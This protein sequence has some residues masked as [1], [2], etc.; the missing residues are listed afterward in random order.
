MNIHEID[1]LGKQALKIAR[2]TILSY[3]GSE[4][5]VQYKA[6]AT[7]VTIADQ[8]AEEHMREFFSK[9]MDC[10][11]VGEEHG[12]KDLKK[13][14]VWVM[15]PIDGTKSFVREVPLFGS[16]VAC[17]KN[18]EPIW[19]SIDIHAQNKQVIAGKG[20]GCKMNGAPVKVSQ[21]SSKS[22]S[23]LLTGTVNTFSSFGM[24]FQLDRLRKDFGLYRGWGDCFGYFQVL[25]GKAEAMVDPVVSLWDI[26][27][28][29]I[30]FE[31]AGGKFSN[32]KGQNFEE[33]LGDITEWNFASDEFTGVGSNGHWHNKVLARF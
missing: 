16:M 32:L 22:Q 23:C 2:K 14:Y 11:F 9:E 28:L 10:G 21:N 29:P 12:S 31:E 24:E 18:G 27:P 1:A 6:D 26:A 20:L 15:D 25:T 30:L 19:G 4:V 7:P 33:M 5:G 13:E 8:L 17:L 3:Y